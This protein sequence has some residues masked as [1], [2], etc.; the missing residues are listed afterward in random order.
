MAILLPEGK[1]SFN[2]SAGVPLVGGKLWT[3]AVG[4]NTPKATYS[5]AAGTIAN[6]NP[7]ILD[8]RGE[9]T[10][11]WS[12]D[13]KAVLTDSVDAVIWTID[14]IKDTEKQIDDFETAFRAEF[15]A[16]SGAS[17]IGFMQS[18]TGVVKQTLQEIVSEQVSLTSFMT[19]EDRTANRLAPGS[20]DLSY[21]VQAAL[22]FTVGNRRK[23]FVPRGR[24][25]IGT[26]VST[27]Y[28][29]I[30]EGESI[31]PAE[32]PLVPQGYSG[33]VFESAVTGDYCF[34]FGS[35][36]Y[37]RGGEYRNFK[38][39]GQGI[40]GSGIYFKNQGWDMRLDSVTV[41]GFNGNGVTF[42]YIQDA[43]ISS[44]GVIDCGIEGTTGAVK[45]I[46]N[47]NSVLFERPHFE[48]SPFLLDMD[49]C[50]DIAFIGFHFEVSEYSDVS[51]MPLNRYSRS[52][53]VSLVGC[54]NIEF[55]SGLFA[56]GSVQANA[57]HFSVAETSIGPFLSIK[58]SSSVKV[59]ASRFGQ[60]D[61]LKSSN[62]LS[63]SDGSERCIIDS[64][65][66][67]NVFIGAYSIVLAG[68]KFINNSV[69][70]HDLGGTSFYGL[71]NSPSG[72]R[73]S[74][75]NNQFWCFNSSGLAKT[76]GYL[77][78]SNT[79]S[80]NLLIGDN[81]YLI[82]KSFKHHNANCAVLR[83]SHTRNQVLV[84]GM[85]T[86]DLE[87][88]PMDTIFGF[89]TGTT[90]IAPI[91][92]PCRGQEVRFFNYGATSATVEHGGIVIMHDAAHAVIP[93]NG[94]LTLAEPNNGYLPELGRSW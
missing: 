62:C 61:P 84:D 69:V 63:I 52:P 3:Y 54:S 85:T 5:D 35:G 79:L 72:Q 93:T 13:Y 44:L 19:V 64:C 82:T 16:S 34:E 68:T 10:V 80:D 77:F 78:Y 43:M 57:A 53:Q 66:F 86:L 30:I 49:N 46:N 76:I 71:A 40:T 36:T 94:Y 81:E 89:S 83:N 6:T 51:L 20:V 26:K 47:C 1:Q 73:S 17:S 11:F 9:A 75:E 32:T 58:S 41:E 25:K 59:Y 23:L 22:N 87:K 56:L 18:G 45:M 60:T 92:N 29:P 31:S 15:A 2:N 12:G 7:V 8:S 55:G 90:V 91:V 4:T 70:F 38:V 88:Y 50:N 37:C 74:V 27:P 28:A 67:E 33:V 39:Y 24:Y 42:D 14:G 21:A 48:I 65:T